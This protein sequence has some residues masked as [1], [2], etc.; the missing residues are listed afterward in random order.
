MTI[1][2]SAE[3]ITSSTSGWSVN[4]SRIAMPTTIRPHTVTA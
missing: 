4:S 2:L 3:P 1:A